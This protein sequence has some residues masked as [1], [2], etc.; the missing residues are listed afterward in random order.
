MPIILT[1]VIR[2]T[3]PSIFADKLC[4]KSD[5]KA[6]KFT[7]TNNNSYML[8]QEAISELIHRS[9]QDPYKRKAI[10]ALKEV[11]RDLLGLINNPRLIMYF[12]TS[13]AFKSVLDFKIT[14][15]N[16][17]IYAGDADK[18]QNII[19]KNPDYTLRLKVISELIRSS[20]G[21][22][23]KINAIKI[24][25]HIAPDLVKIVFDANLHIHFKKFHESINLKT[26]AITGLK[27]AGKAEE[28]KIILTNKNIDP[29]HIGTEAARTLLRLNEDIYRPYL[30]GLLSKSKKEIPENI[31]NAIRK[32]LE[33]PKNDPKEKILQYKI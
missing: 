7:I 27:Q 9:T 11:S 31:K 23:N 4:S 21:E 10:K 25:G 24:L 3:K 19:S 26:A 29:E 1:G 16:G 14:A 6:L 13:D 33:A 2:G 30:E 17:L 22:N 32:V 5:F 15:S 12:A 20:A 28:L 18:I 8:K